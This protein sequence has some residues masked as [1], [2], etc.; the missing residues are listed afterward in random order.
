MKSNDKVYFKLEKY[1][2]GLEDG[3]QC[4]AIFYCDSS[5]IVTETEGGGRTEMYGGQT[6]TS[7][8][9]RAHCKMLRKYCIFGC[10]THFGHI[11]AS[12][13]ANE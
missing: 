4:K 3:G 5:S 2:L 1:R 9:S 12:P 10:R 11:A 13:Y 8:R 6:R 7:Y